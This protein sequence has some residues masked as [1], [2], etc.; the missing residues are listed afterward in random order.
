MKLYLITLFFFLFFH[1]P[2]SALTLK[3]EVIDAETHEPLSFV[4]I[5]IKGSRYGTASNT[6]GSFVINV[7]EEHK[8]STL[9]FSCIGYETKSLSVQEVLRQK[10]VQLRPSVVSLDEVTVMPDSTLRSFSRKA[11]LKIPS[12]YP[13]VKTEYQGFF[14]ESLQSEAGDYLRLVEASLKRRK[15]VIIIGKPEQYRLSK[16]GSMSTRTRRMNFR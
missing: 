5:G 15:L 12:N 1:L 9:Q 16:L 10:K 6:S 7:P 4:N 14:R 3:G 11:Y 13:N 8:N 2:L